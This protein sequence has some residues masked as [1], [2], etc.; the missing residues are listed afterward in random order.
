MLQ[1]SL[2]QKG[3]SL[4]EL[5]VVVAIIGILAAIAVP[6]MTKFQA[7]ARQSEAKTQLTSLY[8]AMKAFH[9]EYAAYHA[10]FGAIG[11][12]PEGKI[13]Y[14]VGF[15]GITG[16]PGS[17]NGYTGVGRGDGAS[18][19]SYSAN[20]TQTVNWCTASGGS[21][22]SCQVLNGVNNSAPAAITNAAVNNTT[23]VFTARALANISSGLAD[24]EWTIDQNKSMVNAV[25]GINT[26]ATAGP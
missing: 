18:A 22:G 10:H 21:A 8:T 11:Y 2:N 20:Q 16:I 5:M 24:D 25:D 12:T 4:V 26:A 19:W 3:F 13:R 23:G 9:T 7:K 6:Q 17:T 15:S 1:K 14:N